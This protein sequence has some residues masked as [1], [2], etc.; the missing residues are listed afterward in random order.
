MTDPAGSSRQAPEGLHRRGYDPQAS[1][2]LDGVR[3]L[4]LSRL[5]AGNVMTQ[6]LGDF[7]VATTRLRTVVLAKGSLLS[8]VVVRVIADDVTNQQR[9]R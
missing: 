5:F 6:M 4:D 7:C 1:G 3:V 2:P 8:W 9:V